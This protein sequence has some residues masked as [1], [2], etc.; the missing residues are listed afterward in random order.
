MQEFTSLWT[1]FIAAAQ[2]PLT[3]A[4]TH[5][6]CVTSYS[7]MSVS[8][9]AFSAFFLNVNA[10]KAATS[11]LWHSASCSHHV[12]TAAENNRQSYFPVVL[13]QTEKKHKN[14]TRLP[15]AAFSSNPWRS[16]FSSVLPATSVAHLN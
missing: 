3:H 16:C 7:G 14:T 13:E 12:C 15:L 1:Y 9:D 10:R 5:T 2:G 8:R 11:S 4:R 6:H